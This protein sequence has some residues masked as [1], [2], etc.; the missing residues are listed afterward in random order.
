MIHPK[1]FAAIITY[2]QDQ[3]EQIVVDPLTIIHLDI[4]A[5][6]ITCIQNLLVLIAAHTGALTVVHII[7]EYP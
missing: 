4:Y 3:Q 5:V 2:C 7:Q 6:D 1:A